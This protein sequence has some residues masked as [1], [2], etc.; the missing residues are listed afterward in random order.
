MYGNRKQ[1]LVT[2]YFT[3]QSSMCVTGALFNHVQQS[4]GSSRN[5]MCKILCR[6]KWTWVRGG[7]QGMVELCPRLFPAFG[8]FFFGFPMVSIFPKVHLINP[9]VSDLGATLC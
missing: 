8:S 1:G 3:T 7:L 4:P 9:E 5:D 6:P 2:Q